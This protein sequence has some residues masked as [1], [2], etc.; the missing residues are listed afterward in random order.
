[1]MTDDLRQDVRY[2]WRQLRRNPAF[3][4]AAVITLAIGI[5]ANSAVFSVVSGVLLEP[6]PYEAPEEI[7][8]VNTAFP[9][10]GF[11]EFWMA[12]PEYFELREWN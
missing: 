12:P 6:L 8:T 10:M 4:A 9:T 3:T 11:E 7:V 2:A 1:M 5:G